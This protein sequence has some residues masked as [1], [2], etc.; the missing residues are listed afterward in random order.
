MDPRTATL[1]M[2]GTINWISSWYDPASDKPAGELASEFAKLYL[3]GVSPID[4]KSVETFKGVADRVLE[5]YTTTASTRKGRG[6]Q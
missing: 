4:G 3:R 5:S 6:R 1:A 2:F